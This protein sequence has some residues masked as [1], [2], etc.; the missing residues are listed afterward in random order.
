G[1]NVE[2][3]PRS[4]PKMNSGTSNTTGGTTIS[5]TSS[6]RSASRPRK[7]HREKPQAASDAIAR[8]AATEALVRITLFANQRGNWSLSAARKP[9]SDAW[10]GGE[11]GWSRNA[12][13][14]LNAAASIT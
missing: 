6:E 12:A 3:Q 7:L 8:V 4:A 10:K 1:R 14:V 2:I 11:N 5:D 13:C 9:W